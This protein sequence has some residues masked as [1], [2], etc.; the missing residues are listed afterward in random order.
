[1]SCWREFNFLSPRVKNIALKYFNWTSKPPLEVGEQNEGC[2]GH[3]LRPALHS[4]CLA[5][6]PPALFPPPSPQL[7]TKRSFIFSLSH[8]AGALE[9]TECKY[10]TD[11]EVGYFE[12]DISHFP[13]FLFSLLSCF[14]F[15][16]KTF[17]GKT[18]QISF[19]LLL[20]RKTVSWK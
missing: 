4:S 16:M 8:F 11:S 1:M 10:C 15:Q 20:R 3:C 2:R 19:L 7:T 9:L 18:F 13:N 5:A 6:A 12:N 17:T 14:V